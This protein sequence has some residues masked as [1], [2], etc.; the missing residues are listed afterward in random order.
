MV[1]RVVG[2]QLAVFVGVLGGHDVGWALWA[3]LGPGSAGGALAGRENKG[4]G[5]DLDG[6]RTPRKETGDSF[7]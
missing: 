4:L 7:C 3:R 6:G 2:E 1:P 5:V